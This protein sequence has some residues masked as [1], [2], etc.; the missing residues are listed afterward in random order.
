MV[1]SDTLDQ[2]YTEHSI[3]N[4]QNIEYT[5][6]SGA[7]GTTSRTGHTLGHKTN[8]IK[9]KKTEIIFNIF[10]NHNGLKLEINYLKNWRKTRKLIY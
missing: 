10:S 2:I 6:F 7:H 1:L 8:V 3:P 5:F 9:F 4:Q